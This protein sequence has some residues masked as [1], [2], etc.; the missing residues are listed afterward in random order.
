MCI[1]MILANISEQ[2]TILFVNGKSGISH[3]T[4][5]SLLMSIKD[6][7]QLLRW[8]GALSVQ[9]SLTWREL[10]GKII[11]DPQEK[12][13]I[14][15]QLDISPLT[16]TRWVSGES[17]PRPQ[18]LRHLLMALPAYRK[19]F[20]E[21]MQ[22]EFGL[23]LSEPIGVDDNLDEIPVDVYAQVLKVYVSLP[24]ILHFT[25]L[26]D[27]ILQHAIKQLDPNAVG[28]EITIAQC[29]PPDKNNKVRS[30]CECVGRGTSLRSREL[31]QRTWFLGS[32]S[33]TGYVVATGCP[34]VVQNRQDGENIFPIYWVEWEESV[35]AQPIL[36]A[37]RVAGCL[38]VSCTQPNYFL[39]P[40][41]RALIQSYAELLSIAFDAR[42]FYELRN[43]ELEDM[44]PFEV[45]R[46]YIYSFH[47]KVSQIMH[48]CHVSLLEAEQLA[49]KRIETELLHHDTLNEM[50][51]QGVKVGGV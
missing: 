36:R 42:D 23:S 6:A 39:S 25:S 26:C 49:W 4:Q 17:T 32:N 7:R 33:L 1:V 46:P 44:P 37:D 28:I 15:N 45:Q 18:N 12:Q 35:M 30:L 22:E 41:R 43:I 16:L 38:L 40:V 34:L 2:I 14:A 48:E 5:L 29:L 8:Y 13:H 47:S 24:K 51:S 50:V 19:E 3:L 21:L 11:R 20:L 9:D 31:R 27:I 10:L